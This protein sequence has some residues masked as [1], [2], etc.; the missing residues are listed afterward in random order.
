MLKA[1]LKTQLAAFLAGFSGASGRAGGKKAAPGKGRKI[2][3]ALLM[4][5]CFVVFVGM[6]FML[7]SQL[8]AAFGGT[9]YAWLYF[10]LYAILA[11]A[12]MFIGSVFTAKSQL[13]EARDNDLLLSMPIPPHRIL[14]AR[15]LALVLLNTVFAL[16]AAIPALAA[17]CISGY[18]SA[19]GVLAFL[20]LFPA[21]NLFTLAV[22]SLLAWLLSVLTSRMRNK[23]VVTL[24]FSALFLL[25][26]F[27]A[28]GRI[29]TYVAA[30]A[31][32]GARIADS[33]RGV[34]P[35]VWLGAAMAEGSASAL[36]GS[37]ALLLVPFALVYL[38]LAR[39]FTGIV[40]TRRGAAKRQ[41]REKAMHTASPR[42]A[43]LRREFARLGSSAGYMLNAGLG[44]LFSVIVTGFLL[45]GWAKVDTLLQQ[46]GL[47]REMLTAALAVVIVFLLCTLTF[48]ASSVSLEGQNLWIVRSAPCASAEVLMAKRQ[49]H[50]LLALAAALLPA[51]G[52]ALRI[53]VLSALAVALAGTGFALI[54]ADI[55][56]IENLRHP[57][58]TWQNEMQP[59]KQGAAV[60]LTMLIMMGLAA[61]ATLAYLFVGTWMDIRLYLLLWAA[62]LLLFDALCV[63]WIRTKGVERF[64]S[65]G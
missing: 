57:N 40:A 51:L 9:E 11:F 42:Q 62:V 1:L 25:A 8:A 35:L 45:F 38:L 19:M 26:Y 36:L 22:T 44:L 49:M 12:L 2:L 63:R 65:L 20:L 28:V 50:A 34:S 3:F 46:M 21:L 64:E 41:Y 18:A 15:M 43:L 48:S 23:N 55:G 52:A 6:F 32:N 30:L 24:V 16:V 37:L 17:W 47:G 58:L 60:G 54:T 27:V 13:F 59:I 56:L 29:N 31:A 7:F 39:S 5:Y 53:G 4:L 33:L 61:L 14:A 10:A